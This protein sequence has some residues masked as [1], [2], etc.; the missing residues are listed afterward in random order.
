ME[1]AWRQKYQAAEEIGATA[2]DEKKAPELGDIEVRA[3]GTLHTGRGQGGLSV[4]RREGLALW[5]GGAL[6]PKP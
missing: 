1:E 6:N 5:A 2:D 3:M 4:E